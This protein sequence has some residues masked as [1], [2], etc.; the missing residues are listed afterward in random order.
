MSLP[1]SDK[2]LF[3]DIEVDHMRDIC[4]FH[5]FLERTYRDNNKERFVAFFADE[6][7]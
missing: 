1:G 6:K 5:G 3:F 7:P 2:A 4:Y